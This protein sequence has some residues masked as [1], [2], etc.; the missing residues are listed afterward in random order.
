MAA[1]AT[2][3][4]P[5]PGPDPSSVP[6]A[7]PARGADPAPARRPGP[8]TSVGR[9]I[10]GILVGFDEQV[11]RRQPPAQERV[12]QVDRLGTVVS[13]AGLTVTLPETARPSAD[14][15][16]IGTAGGADEDEPAT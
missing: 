15:I 1:R 10:G 2:R 4:G 3:P 7:Q 5:D 6:A 14:S 11:W 9:T 13:G 16:L 8:G 12:E